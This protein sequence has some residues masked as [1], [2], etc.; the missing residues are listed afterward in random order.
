MSQV[1]IGHRGMDKVCG[2]VTAFPEL[3]SIVAAIFSKARQ[4]TLPNGTKVWTKVL[5]GGSCLAVDLNGIRYVEQN[6]TKNSAEAKRARE[7]AK[8]VW[9]IRT[10]SADGKPLAK[11]IYIGKIEGG[12]VRKK[13]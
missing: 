13:E 10:H 11:G 4:F 12:V 9:A 2:P 7:G 6:R 5:A 3:N 1:Q 8:I